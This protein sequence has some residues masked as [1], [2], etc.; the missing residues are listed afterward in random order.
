MTRYTSG[1]SPFLLEQMF[2]F[3]TMPPYRVGGDGRIR[4]ARVRDILNRAMVT[5]VISLSSPSPALAL[6]RRMP[7]NPGRG[8]THHGFVDRRAHPPIGVVACIGANWPALPAR[9]PHTGVALPATVS[10]RRTTVDP[11]GHGRRSRREMFTC[12]DIKL[13]I[14]C[15]VRPA[16][17]LSSCISLSPPTPRVRRQPPRGHPRGVVDGRGAMT[18][19]CRTRPRMVRGVGNGPHVPPSDVACATDLLAAMV[20][21]GQVL[22]GAARGCTHR[23][24]VRPDCGR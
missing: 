12:I 23:R 3:I 15:L 8:R 18:T 1:A 22:T 2:Y 13:L 21:M 6:A 16:R 5:L 14:A 4:C 9:T 20:R 11:I 10:A 24:D 17:P 19:G 7:G